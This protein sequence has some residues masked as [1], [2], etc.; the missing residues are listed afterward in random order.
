[1]S[2]WLIETFE[3]D[4][5]FARGIQFII[6]VL[7]V[8][9]LIAVFVWVMRRISG[10]RFSGS[11]NRQPRISIMDAAALDTRR[12]LIL[13]RRDN[14]EHLLLVGGPSDVVVEQNI[15][16]GM[17]VGAGYGR[18]TSAPQVA[19]VT[20]A[21]YPE[22]APEFPSAAPPAPPAVPP[23]APVAEPSAPAVAA[24]RQA[25]PLRRPAEPAAEPRPSAATPLRPRPGTT[26]PGPVRRTEPDLPGSERP[27]QP[28]T[29]AS[30]QPSAVDPS[31]AST[32]SPLRR[33]GASVAAAG[34]AVASLTRD[35]VGRGAAGTGNAGS[36]AAP[37]STDRPA[38]R[39]NEPAVRRMVTPPSSGPAATARTA[40]FQPPEVKGETRGE[41]KVEPKGSDDKP[42]SGPQ[43]PT[44]TI[45]PAAPPSEAAPSPANGAART[46][47][48]VRTEPRP[49]TPL[50]SQLEDSLLNA[51][52]EPAPTPSEPKLAP[53]V[54]AAPKPAAAEPRPAPAPQAPA[55]KEPDPGQ[56][57][58]EEPKPEPEPAAASQEADP[59]PAEQKKPDQPV[60]SPITIDAIEEEMAKLLNEISGNKSR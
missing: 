58:A 31:P 10:A 13:I 40:F 9:A 50:S 43:A 26:S 18:G 11:R 49:S 24:P 39:P 46:P 29:S 20:T 48:P 28:A 33:A 37:S 41:T 38:A 17:P 30:S 60:E 57:K 8:L 56:A 55:A 25:P 19:P 27:A 34:A 21:A 54:T 2:E 4:P 14:V 32:I 5:G 47:P 12:R 45:E 36:P 3:M 22:P 15:V 16:R 7:V 44:P 1:M 23:A 6:A 52:A 51:L 42:K 53:E 59:K 35:A